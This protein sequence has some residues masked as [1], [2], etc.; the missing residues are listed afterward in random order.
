MQLEQIKGKGRRRVIMT[1]WN[2]KRSSL[3]GGV[4][5]L[6][7]KNKDFRERGGVVYNGETE[8]INRS[9]GVTPETGGNRFVQKAILLWRGGE[10][11][12]NHT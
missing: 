6:S 5:T 3:K 10:G 1:V 7:S 2:S 9:E 8:H 11:C 4:H 12:T